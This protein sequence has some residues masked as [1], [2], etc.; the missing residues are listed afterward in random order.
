M[1]HVFYNTYQQGQDLLM[2]GFNSFNLFMPSPPVF[3][4]T[5]A[6]ILHPCEF[7]C[8]VYFV[9]YFLAIP[10]MYMILPIYSITNLNTVSWGTREEK[11]GDHDGEELPDGFDIRSHFS[12][13]FPLFQMLNEAIPASKEEAMAS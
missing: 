11:S 10:C 3:S 9:L 6:G 2:T 13:H 5:I 1:R 7:G 8:V 4:F 12:A